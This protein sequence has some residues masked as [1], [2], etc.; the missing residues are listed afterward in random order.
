MYGAQLL[1]LWAF[2]LALA[3]ALYLAPK[4]IAAALKYGI[5]D[6][7][8]GALKVHRDP[9][10][11]LGGLVIFMSVIISLAST[12]A[13][14]EELLATLL[15]ASIVV[16][17][18]LVD[19]LGTLTPKDKI[20]GQL[21]AALVLVKAGVEVRLE[22]LPLLLPELASVVWMLTVMNAFNILDVSDGLATTAAL[23]G[24]LGLA[25][26]A[27]LN[28]DALILVLS[29]SVA[30]AALGFLWF[31]RQPA[32]MYLGDTG[33]LL[34]GALLGSLVLM[35]R[36]STTNEISPLFAPLCFLA[37]PLFDLT[38]VVVARLAAR[39]PI[40]HGSPDHFAVRLRDAGVAPRHIALVSA[41][42][43]A[44]FAAVGVM[45]TMLDNAGIVGVAVL[46]FLAGLALLVL[47][48][49]RFPA[50]TSPRFRAR[51]VLAPAAESTK[52]AGAASSVVDDRT[53]SPSTTV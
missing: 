49:V 26:L 46:T 27:F 35:S 5:V 7:P 11:Y 8:Q 50:R 47:V 44:V 18:G 15:C 29:M 3:V 33:S 30:G 40:Y 25:V 36:Y 10:P 23:V 39:K 12:F 22:G 45:S 48:I 28:G 1:P 37:V 17:V 31:N 20:L 53:S 9:V 21:L 2:L 32:R 43:G 14:D 34:L 41:V 4:L 42:V 6:K 52:G 38:L 13:F 16:S 19:D 51:P 24:A